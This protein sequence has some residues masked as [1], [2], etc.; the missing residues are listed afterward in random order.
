MA[1][2]SRDLGQDVPGSKNLIQDNI[3]PLFCSLSSTSPRLFPDWV[4][5]FAGSAVI[6]HESSG[7]EFIG[8][9]R[10]LH[11]SQHS[12]K[13]VEMGAWLGKKSE[14]QKPEQQSLN[15][16]KTRRKIVPVSNNDP[17]E[18]TTTCFLLQPSHLH[19]T[20]CPP[21]PPRQ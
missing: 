2:T 6:F 17:C 8:G 3:G 14:I 7:M 12:K 18:S 5:V 15:C 21:P 1:G 19:P 10:A 9:L 20:S 16:M 11:S 13:S 4:T